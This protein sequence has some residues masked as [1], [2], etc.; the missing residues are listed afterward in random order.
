MVIKKLPEHNERI[1]DIAD[2]NTGRVH[3]V[4]FLG[5]IGD[6]A[7]RERVAQIV[8]LEMRTLA[9]EKR[10]PAQRASIIGETADFARGKLAAH[11]ALDQNTGGAQRL[12]IFSQGVNGIHKQLLCLCPPAGWKQF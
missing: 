5:N 8:L 3:V 11:R 1:A 9:D 2:E 6:R 10:V 7:A 4:L 12:N